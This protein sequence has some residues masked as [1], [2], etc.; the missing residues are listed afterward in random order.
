M[1]GW[2]VAEFLVADT[3]VRLAFFESGILDS[4]ASC[5]SLRRLYKY[6]ISRSIRR[7][8]QSLADMRVDASG[9]RTASGQIRLGR[10][11]TLRRDHPKLKPK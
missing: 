4:L 1:R 3:D 11:C 2:S 5:S 10:H 6:L 8:V 9:E 7:K